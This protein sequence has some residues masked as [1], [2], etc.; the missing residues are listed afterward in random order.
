MSY[1][2]IKEIVHQSRELLEFIDNNGDRVKIK[3]PFIRK[4]YH[5]KEQPYTSPLEQFDFVEYDLAKGKVII[6]KKMTRKVLTST[7]EVLFV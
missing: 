1:A 4:L 7:L 3:S 6:D 5:G 2:Y